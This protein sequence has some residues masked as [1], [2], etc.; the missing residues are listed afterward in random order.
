M[1]S[2]KNCRAL[3]FISSGIRKGNIISIKLSEPRYNCV[4]GNKIVIIEDKPY[5]ENC[6]ERTTRRKR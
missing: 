1:V 6:T 3:E 5:C 2:C 4:F